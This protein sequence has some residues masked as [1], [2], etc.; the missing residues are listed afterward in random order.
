MHDPLLALLMR[1]LIFIIRGQVKKKK[2]N[3]LEIQKE[4]LEN[5]CRYPQPT[6][7]E[8]G[9]YHLEH[10]IYIIHVACRGWEM[11]YYRISLIG[12]R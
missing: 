4:K 3:R 8:Q 10:S 12:R 5:K 6:I 7:R 11:E 2:Q 1:I 9:H